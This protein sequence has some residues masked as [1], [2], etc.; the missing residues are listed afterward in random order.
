MEGAEAGEVHTS[1]AELHALANH[2]HDVCRVL[3][4]SYDVVGDFWHRLKNLITNE[5]GGFITNEADA[6]ISI[7]GFESI[8]WK[9]ITCA[10]VCAS[11]ASPA[12]LVSLHPL[13][14]NNNL[15]IIF[16]GGGGT[17]L[18]EGVINPV[19]ALFSND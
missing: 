7:K 8:I 16:M 1:F 19:A 12:G 5:G 9:T 3:Y 15:V 2:L 17:G 10:C 14:N 4:A 13:K 11:R 6:L 18:S